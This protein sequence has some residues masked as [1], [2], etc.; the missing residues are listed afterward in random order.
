[1]KLILLSDLHLGAA[2]LAGRDP[3]VLLHTAIAHI[4]DQHSDADA[5]IL[6]GDLADAGG[7]ENYLDLKAA[8]QE[9][10]MPVHVTL[11]NHDDRKAYNAVFNSSG[12]ACSSPIIAGYSCHLVD[13]LDPGKVGG[14]LDGGRLDALDKALTEASSPG[15]VFLHHPPIRTF[16]PAFDR[17]GL[18]DRGL[19]ASLLARHGDKLLGLCFGHCHLP[20]SGTVAGLPAFCVPSLLNQSRPVFARPEYRA[21]PDL[22]PGYGVLF[23]DGAGLAFHAI[24]FGNQLQE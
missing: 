4:R 11:G 16:V 17:D 24:T 21:N 23:A 14:S 12:F 9:V 6:L 15:F 2:S 3:L 18:G 22:P 13:T 20:L 1:M 5:L 7:Q 19:L 8:L 10:D